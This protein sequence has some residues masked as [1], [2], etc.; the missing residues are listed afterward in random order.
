[1]AAWVSWS[2]LTAFTDSGPSELLVFQEQFKLY[3]INHAHCDSETQRC[4]ASALQYEAKI[5]PERGATHP[6][7]GGRGCITNPDKRAETTKE[8]EGN[9]RSET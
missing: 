5:S 1:M 9:G 3:R 6:G 4:D 7:K 2:D 8:N